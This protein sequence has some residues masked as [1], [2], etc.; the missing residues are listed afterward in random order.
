MNILESPNI[1]IAGFSN[2]VDLDKTDHDE[3]SHLN[4]QCLSFSL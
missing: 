2:T 3:P 4:L 1:T